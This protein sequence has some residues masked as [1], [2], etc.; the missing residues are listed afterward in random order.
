MSLSVG[1]L[2]IKQVDGLLSPVIQRREATKNLTTSEGDSF[3]QSD[4]ILLPAE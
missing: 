4:F 3:G 1:G 2:F